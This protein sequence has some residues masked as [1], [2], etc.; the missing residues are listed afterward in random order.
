VPAFLNCGRANINGQ[1]YYIYFFFL[2]GL[3]LGGLPF[4]FP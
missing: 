1:G 2:R 4:V 3:L